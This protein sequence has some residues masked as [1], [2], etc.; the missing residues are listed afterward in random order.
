MRGSELR[1]KGVI[2]RRTNY[3]ESDRILNILAP[4]G[5]ISAL[6]KGVRKEKSKLA[7]GI[8]MFCLSEFTIHQGKSNI[9]IITSAKMLKFYQKILI[10]LPRLELASDILKQI[11]RISEDISSPEHFSLVNQVLSAL[12]LA[13]PLP[14]VEVWFCLNLART[15]GEQINLIRDCYGAPLTSQISYIWD[16]H[17]KA[18]SPLPNLR[19][20][21]DAHT[22]EDLR[23]TQDSRATQNLYTMSNPHTTELVITTDH[24]KFMRLILSSPL[25]VVSKVSNATS[26]LPAI[27]PIARAS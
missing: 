21:S 1:T 18:L 23:T 17:E 13:L 14:L 25:L 20:T 4:E 2:L 8:E 22:T 12:D 15:N 27:L 10:E 26:L 5:R 16:F 3:G 19:T 6:A 9:A 7:G 11:G 24:I